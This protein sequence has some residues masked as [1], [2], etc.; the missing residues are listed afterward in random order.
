VGYRSEP[1][2]SVEEAKMLGFTPIFDKA[3][4]I[5]L[6]VVYRNM[7]DALSDRPTNTLLQTNPHFA[8]STQASF[9][10]R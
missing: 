2:I 7:I 6:Q 8:R 10:D 1:S 4:K 5:T 3:F 9:G